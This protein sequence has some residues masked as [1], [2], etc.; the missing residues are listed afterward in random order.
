MI[1]LDV[2]ILVMAYTPSCFKRQAIETTMLAAEKAGFGVAVHVL[3]G[4]VGSIGAART[5]GYA[6]G[7]APYVTH[8]DDDDWVAPNA[9]AILQEHL[10]ADVQGVTT[11]ETQVYGDKRTEKPDSRHHLVVARRDLLPDVSDIRF[12]PDQQ[13]VQHLPHAVHIPQCVYYHRLLPDSGSRQQRRAEP[14]AVRAETDRLRIRPA[15]LQ[16]EALTPADMNRIYE[17]EGL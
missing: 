2:H 12:V 10:E 6:Q 7:T 14:E 11:G 3:P 16:A 5:R 17:E 13:V 15:L 8:V 9:F 1:L 4:V